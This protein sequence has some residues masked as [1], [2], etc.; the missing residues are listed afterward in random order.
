MKTT[1]MK[2]LTLLCM[3]FGISSVLLAQNEGEITGKV[4]DPETGK[5]V[6]LAHI[7]LSSEGK[8]VMDL[9]SDFNGMYTASLLK[10]A[11]YD[12]KAILLGYD[13]VVITG[14][15]VGSDAMVYQDILMSEG[16]GLDPFEYKIPLVSKNDMQ[17]ET[18]LTGAELRQ[19]GNDNIV[20]AVIKNVPKVIP[21]ERSGG[22][23]IAGSREDAVLYVIDG[24]RVIGSAYLP[25]NAIKEVNVIT[26]GIPAAYGDF[27][28]GVVEITTKNYAGVY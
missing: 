27:M 23:S 25:M 16:I 7:L 28:G 15:V 10:P 13:T 4:Y 1:S 14:I 11:T 5:A 26:G 21:N 18:T 2:R 9:E 17:E 6:P 8:H 22:I 19:Q 24:V 3:A 12:L 20:D